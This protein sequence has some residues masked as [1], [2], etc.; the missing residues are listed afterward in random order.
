MTQ[1][2]GAPSLAQLKAV[3]SQLCTLPTPRS[4][5]AIIVSRDAI[6][7][8]VANFAAD[9]IIYLPRIE[10]AFAGRIAATPH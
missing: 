8:G 3:G 7:I 9:A 2:S 1:F 4:R 10:A 5:E 6:G